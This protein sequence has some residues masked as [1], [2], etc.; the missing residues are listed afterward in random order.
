MYYRRKILLALI[1]TFG[2][3]LKSTDCEKLLFNLCKLAGK[4]HYDFFPHRFGPFSIVSYYDKQ[5]LTELGLLKPTQGFSL[6]TKR[7][8]I[9]DLKSSD[10]KALLELKASSVR[11][12]ELIKKIYQENPQFTSRSEILGKMFD[13]E[14]IKYLKFAWNTDKS[15]VIFTIGYEGK[16]IDSFLY[17]LISNNIWAVVDVRNNP[18]SMK[19]GF[20]KKGLKDYIE[21]AGMKYFHIPE[22]GIPSA[23]RKGLGQTITHK[24]LFNRYESSLLPKQEDAK[25]YLLDLIAKYPRIVLVCFEA[26]HHFCHRYTL[27]ENLKKEKG[28]SKSIIH[29]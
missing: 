22:L 5:R 25:T 7:S 24:K 27:I 2:G 14:E 15:P 9:N 4:N 23:M 16:T 12:S 3:N 6:N 11:G 28:L 26:D 8:Y 20:S 10:K 17:K 1:E 19:F 29:L 21:K 13:T 18:Q